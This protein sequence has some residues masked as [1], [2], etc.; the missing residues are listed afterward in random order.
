MQVRAAGLLPKKRHAGAYIS[1]PGT[2]RFQAPLHRIVPIAYFSYALRMS[3]I[4]M[5]RFEKMAFLAWSR[6]I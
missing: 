4:S 3:S 5:P 6:W 1:A 2:D